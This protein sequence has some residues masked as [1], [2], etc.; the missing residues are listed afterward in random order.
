MVL[1]FWGE[2]E[3]WVILGKKLDFQELGVEPEGYANEIALFIQATFQP[4]NM[5]NEEIKE[6][7]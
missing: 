1:D 5:V 4:V 3:D 6:D 7:T 2:N